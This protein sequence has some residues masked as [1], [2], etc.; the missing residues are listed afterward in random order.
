MGKR[1]NDKLETM[2]QNIDLKFKDASEEE[3]KE[4]IARGN[5]Q[6][7]ENNNEI[8]KLKET[9][10]T[11]QQLIEVLEGKEESET[12]PRI[13]KAIEDASKELEEAQNKLKD[14][15]LNISKIKNGETNLIAYSKNKN[16]IKQIRTFKESIAKKLPVEIAKRDD[17]KAKMEAAEESL[18][19][20]NTKLANE[21]LTMEMDQYEYNALL[22][23]K[24]QAE[25]DVKEQTE[26]YKKAK[27]RILELQTKIGKCDLAWKTLFAGKSWDEI[28][29]RALDPNTK[30]TR[31]IDEDT[32]LNRKSGIKEDKLINNI[33]KTVDEV[34]NEQE[35]QITNDENADLPVPT[36]KHPRWEKFKNFFKNAGRKIKE[37]FV[38]EEPEQEEVDISEMKNIPQ[39][40]RDQFLEELRRHVD[41]EYGKEIRDQKEAMYAE[42]HKAKAK[43][44]E[45]QEKDER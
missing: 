4:E 33:A 37:L 14:Y 41:K 20:A 29:R 11:K 38:G 17:S 32:K 6:I 1:K 43:E 9:I 30:F 8:E 40:K 45:P 10:K 18:R 19:D 3:I 36:S 13:Q 24:A 34:R 35:D 39:E 5:L 27:D 25:K 31:H 12:S 22:E 28:Q 2:Y 16:Q 7:E 44:S 26:I 21:K 42:Q 23:Q 15:E